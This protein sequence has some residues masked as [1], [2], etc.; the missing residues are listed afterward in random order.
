M[1]LLITGAGSK[2][3]EA[4]ARILLM[5]P[6]RHNLYFTTSGISGFAHPDGEKII[7]CDVS[8][9]KHL[10][11]L[12]LY[13]QPHVII[14]TAA[15]T[16]V[17]RAEIERQQAWKA[18]VCI[19]ENLVAV[20]RLVD[21]HLI[22]FST[23]YVFDGEHGPYVETDTPN[24]LGYYAK[25][26]LAGENVCIGGNIDYTIIR[27]N[28]LYGYTEQKKHD[29]VSWTLHQLDKG[30]PFYVVSDQFSNPTLID[31]VG[32]MVEKI[33]RKRAQGIFHAGGADWVSRYDFAR[34]IARIFRLPED[35]VQ[36]IS[37][38]E[39]RQLA[40]RPMRGGVI[41][42][43]A[44]ALFGMKF[45]GIESGL[46]TMKRQLQSAGCHAWIL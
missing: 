39:L 34:A 36:P 40:P 3:A 10:K 20:C 38:R 12:C 33:I 9:R 7:V 24:P 4:I 35:L 32:Y 2:V 19:V 25:T 21:A 1:R 45:C 23:D 22:H 27:T 29:F 41:A 14:N 44:E 8:N 18:N 43:K 17:D 15:Y 37:T 30:K 11:E 13:I 42:Y 46:L 5:S 31:D 26:K 16:N 6:L 28:V